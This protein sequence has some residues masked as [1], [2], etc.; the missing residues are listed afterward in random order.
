MSDDSDGR[1]AIFLSEYLLDI[2]EG[3]GFLASLSEA[4]RKAVRHSGTRTTIRKGEGL[5]FQG[6]P[7][8]GVW[9]IE[10]G[11]IRTFYAGPSGREITLAYWTPGH[12]VGGPEV[13]GR[14][15]H[16][17]SADALEDGELLF[18]SGMSLR[19]LVCQHPEVALGVI[20]GLIAKGKCYS[21]LIQ[22]LGTRAVADRLKQLLV[23]IADAYGRY[24]DGVTIIERSITYEQVATMVGATRQWVTQ[25]LDK[26]ESDGVLSVTRRE[27]RI[28]RLSAL[29]E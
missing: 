28:Y 6:D 23:I 24:E 26:L 14:G 13:F 18:L 3:A 17:W 10:S 20:D 16:V 1:S 4:G 5:F 27:I 11:R 21:A 8:T 7:H 2:N 25:S 12:F 29:M 22:M 19:N 9:V 15:R